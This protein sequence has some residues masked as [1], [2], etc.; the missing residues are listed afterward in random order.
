MSLTDVMSGM[1]LTIFPQIALV[2]FAITF[3]AILIRVCTYPRDE[4]GR[5]SRLPLEDGP[6]EAPRAGS[7]TKRGAGHG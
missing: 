4:I 7:E 5:R 1:H 6:R 3:V 2:I